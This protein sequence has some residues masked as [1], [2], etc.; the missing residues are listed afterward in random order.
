LIFKQNG[1]I[2]LDIACEFFILLRFRWRNTKNN[3][4]AET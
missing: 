2:S 4:Q 3:I 1:S